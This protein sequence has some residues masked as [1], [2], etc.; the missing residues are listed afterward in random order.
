MNTSATLSDVE[1]QIN[2]CSARH[3]DCDACRFQDQ[4]QQE[5]DRFVG[6]ATNGSDI[7]NP[8]RWIKFEKRMQRF[9]QIGQI[10]SIVGPLCFSA[11]VVFISAF[12]WGSVL[13]L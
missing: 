6:R 8:Q 12:Y 7:I 11:A 4:C 2:E 10:N 3:N 5:W 13:M 1:K 9:Q